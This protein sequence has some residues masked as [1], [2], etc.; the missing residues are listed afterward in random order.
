MPG[1]GKR[2]EKLDQQTIAHYKEVLIEPSIN[3]NKRMLEE[4]FRDCSDAV[5]R[6]FTMENGPDALICYVDGIVLSTAVDEVLK[7]LMVLQGNAFDIGTI[8]KNTLPVVQ[9]STAEQYGELLTAVLSGD[10]VLLVEGSTLALVLGLRGTE[11]RTVSEPETETVVRGPREGFNE[12][13]RTNTSLIRTKIKSPRLKMKSFVVGTETKTDVVVSYLAGIADPELVQEIE[14]RIKRICIDGVLESG[15]IEELIQDEAYSPF[16]QIQNTERPDT[17]A[18]ALLEGRVAIIVNGTPFVLLA[19][20]GFW[21]WLQA[22]E[23]YYERFMAGSLLRI[24]RFI[25]LFIA[26]LTPALYIAATTYHPEMIPTSLLLSIA[27]SREAIPFP[28]VVEALIMEVAFEG[29]REAGIRLPRTVGQAVS[30]LGALVVGQAAVQAGIVSAAMVIVV[31]LT[32]I[33]SFTLPRYNA[34]ISIRMLRFPLMLLASVFGL[35]G[36]VIGVMAFMGHM[37]KLRS[38]GV[39]YLAPV[40]PISFSDWKDIFIRAP[41]QK[42]NRR[43][44]FM[45]VQDQQRQQDASSIAVDKGD[46]A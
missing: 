40:A 1:K 39:P 5:F 9:T 28:A 12:H 31:S 18:A 6:E 2:E 35:L 38:F 10:S 13:L 46:E 37:A 22:S 41:W 36:I 20:F 23:D 30:I 4:I 29:L 32:G 45:N 19:P 42:M 25:F 14:D 11:G 26:L 3:Q 24:L 8:A 27:A 17:V 33:A 7:S 21:Q 43:P 44:S 15:Y 34:A 16:P